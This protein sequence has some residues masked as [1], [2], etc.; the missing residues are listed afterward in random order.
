M[1]V[2]ILSKEQRSR[3]VSELLLVH[4]PLS[5]KEIGEIAI[6]CIDQHLATDDLDQRGEIAIHVCD[7][8]SIVLELTLLRKAL[9]RSQ[10]TAVIQ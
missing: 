1:T 2:P 7:L 4:P 5:D 9:N 10:S 3:Y 8:F 6:R